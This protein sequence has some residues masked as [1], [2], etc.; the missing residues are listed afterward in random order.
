MFLREILK[1]NKCCQ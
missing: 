1:I